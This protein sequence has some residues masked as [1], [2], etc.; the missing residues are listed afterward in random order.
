MFE[1][2]Y[3]YTDKLVS[4]LIKVEK[5]KTEITLQDLNYNV[6]SKLTLNAKALDL[7][8]LANMIG[9]E[10]TIKDAER[11]AETRRLDVNNSEMSYILIN[12]RNALEFT[13]SNASDSYSELDLAVILHLHKLVLTNWRE[14]WEANFRQLEGKLSNEWGDDW[15]DYRDTGISPSQ[16]EDEINSLIEWYKSSMPTVNPLVR[17]GLTIERLIEICPFTVGNKHT[18][19]AIA[20]YLLYKNGFASKTFTSVVRNFDLRN[21]KYLTAVDLSRKNFDSS[22]WL[23]A[24][25]E[26]QLK[27]LTDA[28]EN[29]SVYIVE[30]EKSKQQPFLDLNKRQ[31]K[32]LKYLQ[33]IPTIKRED[34]C[35]M[36][37]VSTMTAFRDFDD[38]VRKKLLKVEGRGRGTRYRLTSM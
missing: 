5:A 14:S 17:I 7:F 13:R 20:D 29:I 26:G 37:D 6:K 28:L 21:Q 27:N 36:M 1:P 30:D 8:H 19:I 9:T 16:I 12:F 33:T 22:I 15:I 10:I 4:S 25:V 38:L 24:F 32:V 35:Q 11:L 2:K 18:I 34:Y 23:E 3:T 31:L